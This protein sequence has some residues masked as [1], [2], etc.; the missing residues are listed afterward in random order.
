MLSATV[1]DDPA[2]ADVLLLR[3][4][5]VDIVNEINGGNEVISV[6]VME[7]NDRFTRVTISI[8][9]VGWVW[10]KGTNRCWRWKYWR[11]NDI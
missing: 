9:K 4:R 3:W 11:E 7:M 10:L 5:G 6:T 1:L 8:V 2:V